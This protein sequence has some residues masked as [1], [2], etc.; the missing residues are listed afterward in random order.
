MC[1]LMFFF[2]CRFFFRTTGF[3]I[4]ESRRLPEFWFI[5]AGRMFIR[6]RGMIRM[7]ATCRYLLVK[8]NDEIT[9]FP[10]SY[11]N[12]GF[13]KICYVEILRNHGSCCGMGW[14][15]GY[16]FYAAGRMFGFDMP[17]LPYWFNSEFDVGDRTERRMWR[18]QLAKT[19]TCI[20]HYEKGF[21]SLPETT[22]SC[23]SARRTIPFPFKRYTNTHIH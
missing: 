18:S 11:L 8:R 9:F 15:A 7:R 21:A 3:T 6:N 12:Y 23:Q 16:H 1:F 13:N 5:T 10:E 4:I 17:H 22:R 2:D 14:M 20:V 19:T